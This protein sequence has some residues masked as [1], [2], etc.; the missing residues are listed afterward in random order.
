M[1]LFYTISAQWSNYPKTVEFLLEY[2]KDRRFELWRFFTYAFLHHTYANVGRVHQVTTTS[3]YWH[4][5]LN[6]AVQILVGTSLEWAHGSRVATATYACGI[7]GGK[8]V[9]VSRNHAAV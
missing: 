2:R 9:S 8:Y 1:G 4:L 5:W 3:R 7:V 6:V